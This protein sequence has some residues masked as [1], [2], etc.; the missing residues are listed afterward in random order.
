MS[1]PLQDNQILLPPGRLVQGDLYEPQTKDN[2]GNPL[3]TKTGPNAGKP[4]INYFAGM[5]IPKTP[6]ATH[7]A[8]EPWGA[9]IWAFGHAAWPQG[10][11]QNPSFAWK[12]EDGDSPIPNKNGRKNSESEGMPGHWIVGVSSSFPPKIFDERGEPMLQPGLVKRGYWCETLI[13]MASNENTQNPGIYLNHQMFAYRA[14]GKEIQGGPDARAVGF[15]RAALPAGVTAQPLTNTANLPSQMGAPPAPGAAPG[16]PPP[17]AAPGYAAPPA[18]GYAAPPPAA[19]APP[20][21]YAAPPAPGGYPAPTAVTPQPQF[22]APPGAP[23]PGAPMPPVPGAPTMQAPPPPAAAAPPAM[24]DPL[25][26]PMGYRMANLNGQRYEA[27]R[28]SGW[29]DAMMMQHN[30]MVKL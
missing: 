4:R 8:H 16:A 25:G 28:A 10:Q 23:M 9:K 1:T 30:H 11:G 24:V 6:G 14:P 13:S 29:T 7:W 12:I 18:P 21:G 3:T 15:G 27:F 5:A 19:A 17:P 2:Q 20:P 22:L 26:A